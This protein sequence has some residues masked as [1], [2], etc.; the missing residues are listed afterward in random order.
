[1]SRFDVGSSRN[2]YFSSH[3][4]VVVPDLREHARELHLLLLAAG[5]RRI[6]LRAPVLHLHEIERARSRYRGRAPWARAVVRI[7]SHQHDV[8]DGERK[9][10]LHALREHRALPGQ[11]SAVSSATRRSSYDTSPAD[12]GSS[13]ARSSAASTFLRRSGPR[14][15]LNLCGRKATL[16][17]SR[18]CAPPT[19]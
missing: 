10:E 16:T 17:P 4:L 19:R 5:E 12:G 1:M 11:C 15:T 14:I 8:F 7:A 18:M 9:C 2:R 3:A 13:P 6:R